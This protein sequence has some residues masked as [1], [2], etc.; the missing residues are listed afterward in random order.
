M[1]GENYLEVRF[2]DLVL[3]PRGTARNLLSVLGFAHVEAIIEAFAA[4]VDRSRVGKFRK[5]PPRRRH[6][7]ES[8]LRPALEAFNYGL[9]EDAPRRGWLGWR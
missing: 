9:D 3:D 1:L 4:S 5:M 2:E 7:A 8:V 6:E